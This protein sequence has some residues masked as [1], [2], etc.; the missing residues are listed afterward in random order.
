MCQM[1]NDEKVLWEVK[2]AGVMVCKPCPTCNS[3]EQRKRKDQ[4]L[5]AKL[6]E[7]NRI[8]KRLKDY[9]LKGVS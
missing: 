7:E 6:N 3:K 2:S 1:C 4:T 5:I 9:L 8:E